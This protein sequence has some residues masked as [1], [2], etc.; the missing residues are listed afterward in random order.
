MIRKTGTEGVA[1][2]AL[3]NPTTIGTCFAYPCRVEIRAGPEW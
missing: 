2:P 1:H 3:A